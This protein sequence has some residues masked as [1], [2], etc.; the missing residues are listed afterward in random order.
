MKSEGGKERY[1]FGIGWSGAYY[2]CRRKQN[3]HILC[4]K[5]QSIFSPLVGQMVWILTKRER[6]NVTWNIAL[7]SVRIPT[8]NQGKGQLC[9]EI[10]PGTVTFVGFREIG[11]PDILVCRTSTEDLQLRVKVEMVF[12]GST[13]WCHFFT[14]WEWVRQW[15]SFV[16]SLFQICQMFE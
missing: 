16:S 11:I 6:D 12:V 10:E 15:F 5:F 8:E 9:N 1:Y 14:V 13:L 7:I 4:I 3:S 2:L